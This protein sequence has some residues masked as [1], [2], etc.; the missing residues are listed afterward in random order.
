MKFEI[1]TPD[2]RVFTR[3]TLVPYITKDGRKIKMMEWESTCV[4]CKRPFTVLAFQQVME[5]ERSRSFANRRCRDC[6]DAKPI[7]AAQQRAKIMQLL[8]ANS[9]IE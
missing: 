6:I 3:K 1:F 8:V 2:G 7:K 4:D 9:R 5:Y